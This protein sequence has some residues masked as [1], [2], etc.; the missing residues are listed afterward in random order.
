MFGESSDLILLCIYCKIFHD[1]YYSFKISSAATFVMN[2]RTSLC[3]VYRSVISVQ[4]RQL[5]L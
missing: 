5:K 2:A 3:S 1:V 4:A